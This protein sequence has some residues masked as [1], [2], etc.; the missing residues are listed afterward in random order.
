MRVNHS[1]IRLFAKCLFRGTI[2]TLTVVP[3]PEKEVEG[4]SVNQGRGDFRSTTT[5]LNLPFY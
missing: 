1:S 5:H 4:E 2:R 3:A